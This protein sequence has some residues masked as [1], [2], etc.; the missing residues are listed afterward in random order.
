MSEV[1]AGVS[2]RDAYLSF[3]DQSHYWARKQLHAYR[4]LVSFVHWPVD[5]N[6]DNPTYFQEV[7]RMSVADIASYSEATKN[8]VE[9]IPPGELHEISPTA[10]DF[11]EFT[12]GSI[13]T[14]E[15]G[16]FMLMDE[17]KDLAEDIVAALDHFPI[18]EVSDLFVPDHLQRTDFLG[19]SARSVHELSGELGKR[20]VIACFDGNPEKQ[21]TLR[22]MSYRASRN[23]L[24]SRRSDLRIS[25]PEVRSTE[26]NRLVVDLELERCKARNDIER[27]YGHPTGSHTEAIAFT[28]PPKRKSIGNPGPI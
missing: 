5:E 20:F 24:L 1:S 12:S 26:F 9:S 17:L 14:L 22:K 4:R 11:R 8:Y 6:E 10:R 2:R 25:V 16:V 19:W 21:N 15:F 18:P 13:E 23:D 3:V 7:W 27:R 28:E